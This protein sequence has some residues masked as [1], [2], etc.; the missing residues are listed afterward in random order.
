MSV[1]YTR[2]LSLRSG[3]VL[4]L[5]TELTPSAPYFFGH[6]IPGQLPARLK[7]AARAEPADQYFLVSDPAVASL[8]GARVHND[9]AAS[10]V[11][12]HSVPLAAGEQ[13]KTFAHLER[14]CETLI[15]RG[16]TK[17]SVLVA[18]GG[19][20]VGNVAGLAAGLL[21][22]GIRHAEIPT[23]FTH[24]TDGSLSNKQAVNGRRGKNH[25][26]LYHAPILIWADTHFLASE[27]RRLR[28]AGLVEAVKNGLVDQPEFLFH[29]RAAL[30]PDGS[31]TPEELTDLAYKTVLAKLEIL[32]KDP[33]E[34]HYGIVLEYGH[35]FA[36][37]IEWLAR[38]S[39][40]HG[41]AVGLGLRIAARLAHR[42]GLIPEDIVALHDALV[43]NFLGMQIQLPEAATGAALMQ[44][45]RDDNKRTGPLIRY[46]LLE[47]LGACANPAGG[48]LTAVEDHI[49]LGV[50]HAF[51][52]EER[53]RRGRTP[54][55][56]ARR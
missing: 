25:L 39:L 37:A 51:E 48:Y 26:G 12:T 34:K 2:G 36:H 10:G 35:T 11:A 14:L 3:K 45:M 13:A 47:R 7:A 8:Y 31:Y 41:E 17:R 15:C 1:D 28:D 46:C 55:L 18:L 56:H 22:R 20:S 32:K 43:E 9:L 53:T 40:L 27:P 50:L 29:L 23:T 4:T 19:G 49:V 5:S 44:T 38:G 52:Q 6:Q 42:L 21:F 30:H 33:T 16:A 24:L 54:E